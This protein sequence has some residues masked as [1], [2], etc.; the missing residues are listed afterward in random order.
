MKVINLLL[1]GLVVFIL[2]IIYI[3]IVLTPLILIVMTGS[4]YWAGL[5]PFTMGFGI[6]VIFF[7]GVDLVTFLLKFFMDGN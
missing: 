3:G 1:F 7:V 5:L 6:W 4:M 2:V